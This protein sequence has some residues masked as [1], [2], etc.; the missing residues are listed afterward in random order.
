MPGYIVRKDGVQEIRVSNILRDPD[1]DLL[2]PISEAQRPKGVQCGECGVK[3]DYG[4]SYGYHCGN[5]RCP[6]R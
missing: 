6:R 5:G 2:P 4:V 3:F 1:Y